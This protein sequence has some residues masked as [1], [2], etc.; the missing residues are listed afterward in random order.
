MV[1][2]FPYKILYGGCCGKKQTIVIARSNMDVCSIFSHTFAGD[3][4]LIAYTVSDDTYLIFGGE[5][6]LLHSRD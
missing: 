5:F 4:M 1:E 6:N 3:D 2:E